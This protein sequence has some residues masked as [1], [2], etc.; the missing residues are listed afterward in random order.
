MQ[1]ITI[2][3]Q[4]GIPTEEQCKTGEHKMKLMTLEDALTGPLSGHQ[5][6]VHCDQCHFLLT[7]GE[8][9]RLFICVM[10]R[11]DK[12]SVFCETCVAT[13]KVKAEPLKTDFTTGLFDCCQEQ[14]H[15]A[16]ALFCFPCKL[17]R[18]AHWV[19]FKYRQD[20]KVHGEE[21][22]NEE[23]P[24]VQC[25]ICT[26]TL[27]GFLAFIPHT[28]WIWVIHGGK[29]GSRVRD[30]SGIHNSGSCCDFLCCPVC[31]VARW[32]REKAGKPECG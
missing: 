21:D 32:Q 13:G 28:L 3:A 23:M 25:S 20:G 8:T 2:Q 24:S 12:P 9:E 26:S 29:Q 6:K 5:G 7:R 11:S 10:C 17:G 18:I 14:N 16:D 4:M 27:L 30:Y 31:A 15:C 19:Q 22:G 1:M